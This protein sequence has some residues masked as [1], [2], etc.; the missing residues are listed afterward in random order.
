[1]LELPKKWAVIKTPENK[2]IL[3][4]WVKSQPGF[5]TV[6][7]ISKYPVVLSDSMDGSYSYSNMNFKSKDYT[8]IT[9][10]MFKKFV[11]KENDIPEKWCIKVI[12][13]EIADYCNLNGAAPP[14]HINKD[15]YA[16]FPSFD[17]NTCTTAET[18]QAGYQEI[19][20]EEFRKYI[21]QKS[22]DLSYLIDLFKK[23]NIK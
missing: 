6:W 7:R 15:M 22:N 17:E 19:T 23:L 10:E 5:D 18:I 12:N 3:E 21:L 11:L 16:H 20:Y 9:F 4:N 8:E 2:D 1:M 13:Q 14:Y